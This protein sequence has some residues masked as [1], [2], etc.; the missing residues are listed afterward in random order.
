MDMRMTGKALA[1]TLLVVSALPVYA[2]PVYWDPN[3]GGNGHYYEYYPESTNP[4]TDWTFALA[5]AASLTH[6]GL[7]GYL[8]TITSQAEQ[9]FV[10]NNVMLH[11]QGNSAWL[12]GADAA[13]EGAWAWVTG[14][15]VGDALT[16]FNWSA[17]EPN[18]GTIEN[19]LTMRETTA[20]GGG[21]NDNPDFFFNAYIVEYSDLS[22]VGEAA[23]W[24]GIKSLYR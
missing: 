23:T 1:L 10:W 15:E 8:A 4:F 24:S 20:D 21:W 19:Y 11:D 3:A 6:A 22:V 17:G 5:H 12:G 18:G 9:D 16:Y 2:T 13:Q 7:P 14:P